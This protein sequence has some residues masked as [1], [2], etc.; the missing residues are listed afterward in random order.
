[1]LELKIFESYFE[2]GDIFLRG[3]QAG[4][5]TFFI[6]RIENLL[7]LGFG[8]LLGLGLSLNFPYVWTGGICTYPHYLQTINDL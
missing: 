4:A 5:K 1:M 2:V 8:L 7:G 3:W 6:C